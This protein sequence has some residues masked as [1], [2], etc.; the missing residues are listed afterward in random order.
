MARLDRGAWQDV[1]VVLLC[2]AILAGWVWLAFVA[3]P[4]PTRRGRV[5]QERVRI[6]L[7]ERLGGGR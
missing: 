6:Q 7:E 2:L 3:E 1:A 5:V 4:L